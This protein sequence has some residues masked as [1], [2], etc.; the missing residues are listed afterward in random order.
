[1]NR[2]HF[3]RQAAGAASITTLPLTMVDMAFAQPAGNFSFAFI[4]DAHLQQVK[5]AEFVRHW[6]AG[7][8]RAIDETNQL[9]VRPD[10]VVFGGDLAQSG[11]CAE[12]DHGAE[13]LARLNAKTYHVI[14]EHD[15][16]HDLGEQ[17]SRLFGAQYY[18]FDHKG[19]HFVVLNSVLADEQWLQGKSAAQRMQAISGLRNPDASP[20]RVGDGQRA[21]LAKDLA[22][23]DRATP[24]VVF[25]HAPLQKIHRDWNFWTDD[26]DEVQLLLA[27]FDTSTVIYGHVH[28]V[29]YNRIGNTSYHSVT[30]TSWPWPYPQVA[31]R[32]QAMMPK[33]TV[34]MNRSGGAVERDATGWQIVDLS[35]GNAAL[36]YTLD[37]ARSRNVTV[38]RRSGRVR[39]T[40]RAAVALA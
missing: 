13:L 4:S 24:V 7:F 30:A 40:N 35:N 11:T 22:G 28:Q 15:Y 37:G 17:W 25:S 2:R 6:D 14:G 3:F 31:N 23:I 9:G 27:P 29:Q 38:H 5:G 20:F 21:W 18:S 26:A 36:T 1:V 19:V 34:P 32:A 16:Y 8:K 39:D 12:L 10:F 33:L